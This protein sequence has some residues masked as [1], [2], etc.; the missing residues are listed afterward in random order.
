MVQ[1]YYEGSANMTEQV[2][3]TLTATPSQARAAGT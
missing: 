2:R 1:R 3:V